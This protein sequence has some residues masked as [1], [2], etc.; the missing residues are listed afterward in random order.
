MD[1]CLYMTNSDAE[2][3]FFMYRTYGKFTTKRTSFWNW[4]DSQLVRLPT[5]DK[6]EYYANSICD[7]FFNEL[8]MLLRYYKKHMKPVM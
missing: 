8:H 4:I 2:L 5:Q 1:F 7:S 3:L 6:P